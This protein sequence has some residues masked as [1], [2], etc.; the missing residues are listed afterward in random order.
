MGIKDLKDMQLSHNCAVCGSLNNK[1]IFLCDSFSLFKC[2]DCRNTFLRSD[3]REIYEEKYYI[4]RDAW[5]KNY[6]KGY[7]ENEHP[8]PT[9]KNFLD[10]I[11]KTG[12]SGGKLL[13][14]GCSKGVFLDLAVKR[15]FSVLGLDTSEFAIKYIKDNFSFPVMC[16]DIE[17]ADLPDDSFDIVVMIDVIEHIENLAQVIRESSRIMKPGGLLV[18]D[19]PNEDSLI[20]FI[21]FFLYKLSLSKLKFFVRTNHDI[22]H[23]VSFSPAGMKKLLREHSFK[24][25]KI[26]LFNVDPAV[27]GLNRM[28]TYCAKLVFFIADILHMQNKIVVFAKKI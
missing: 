25:I 21:S 14:I 3:K 23:V 20:N 6:K 13:E 19:T 17:K 15:G 2:K 9:Y 27:K 28:I 8:V 16:A 7:N 1:R 24:V 26:D 11:Q 5:Y 22:E 12:Y 10:T 18:I 4:D